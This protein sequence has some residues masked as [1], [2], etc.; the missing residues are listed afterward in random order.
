MTEEVQHTGSTTYVTVRDTA[1]NVVE[2]RA[3]STITLPPY[4]QPLRIEPWRHEPLYPS[5][6]TALRTGNRKARRAQAALQ[7]GRR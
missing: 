3:Y 2:R 7:R 5:L 1:G 6:G 4:E